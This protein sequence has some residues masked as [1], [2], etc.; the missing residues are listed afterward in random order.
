VGKNAQTFVD[1][2][3]ALPRHAMPIDAQHALTRNASLDWRDV[4]L[5][6]TSVVVLVR[7]VHVLTKCR[8]LFCLPT[9][10]ELTFGKIMKAPRT[11]VNAPIELDTSIDA[12]RRLH[13]YLVTNFPRWSMKVS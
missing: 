4:R 9:L 7:Y 6:N 1:R 2:F 11:F 13:I 3:D 10:G 12:I 5:F 8:L